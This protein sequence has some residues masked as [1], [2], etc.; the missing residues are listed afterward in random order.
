LSY[1]IFV[2]AQPTQQFS[3]LV[4]EWSSGCESS[5]VIAVKTMIA[6]TAIWIG[7]NATSTSSVCAFSTVNATGRIKTQPAFAASFALGWQYAGYVL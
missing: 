7:N 6:Y 5:F 4:A 3:K 2:C 1:G